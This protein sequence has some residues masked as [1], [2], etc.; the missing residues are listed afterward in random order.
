MV[1]RYQFGPFNS[2]DGTMSLM[3]PSL[4]PTEKL[5]KYSDYQE[6][7]AALTTIRNRLRSD[8]ADFETAIGDIQFSYHTANRI[9][10]SQGNASKDDH[11]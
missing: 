3:D 10:T 6:L 7:D 8:P 1:E 2:E 5:V 4:S 9:L 11:G